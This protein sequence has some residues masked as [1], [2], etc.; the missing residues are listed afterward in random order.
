MEGLMAYAR[1][2]LKLFF[3]LDSG[4]Q[5]KA[6]LCMTIH[7]DPL[8][9]ILLPDRLT[10][11]VDIGANPIDGD[12]PYKSMLEKRLCTVVGFEP[13]EKALLALNA[14]KSDL[15]SYLP[16]AVGDGSKGTLKLC[17]APGMTSLLTPE[18]EVLD[19]FPIFSSFGRIIDEIPIETR[20]LDGIVEIPAL[21]FLKIDVQGAELSVFRNGSKRLA[22]AVALQTEV[23]FVTIYK[24]QPVFGDIDLALRALGFIPHM[25]A[26]LDKRMIL[27]LHDES[28]PFAFMNQ[29]LEADFVYVRDF[30]KP[31]KMDSAQLKHLALVAHHCYGSF[32]LAAKCIHELAQR[33]AISRDA[34]AQYLAVIKAG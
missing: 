24:H 20:T 32:D 26:K 5:D 6:F 3:E 14:R 25:L 21:D 7:S 34:V 23:S 9:S 31:D 17:H 4:R 27:P 16:Y 12:A 13:Q 8:F 15:E 18:P 29:I 22:N 11:V 10:A 1:G 33:S 30:T 28:Q 2:W 19:C